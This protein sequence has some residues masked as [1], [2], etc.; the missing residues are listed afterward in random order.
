MNLSIKNGI[1]SSRIY[2]KRDAF[3]EIVSHSF[4]EMFF[5]TVPMLYIFRSLFVL[6]EIV[7]MLGASTIETNF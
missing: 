6:Q 1:V 3:N 2:V 7:L 4:M 5:A